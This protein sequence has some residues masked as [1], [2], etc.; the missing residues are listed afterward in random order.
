MTPTA[1]TVIVIAK[2]PAPG[3]VKTRLQPQFSAE[4]AADLAA[5]ALRDTLRAVRGCRVGQKIIYWAANDDDD[6]SWT[7]G[8]PVV[9]Q[10]DGPLERRLADAFASVWR[11][12]EH[13][14]L[15]VGM[16]TPQMAAADLDVDWKE[17]DAVLGLAPDGGFWAIGL[18]GGNPGAIFADIPM[19]TP[20]TGAAQLARLHDLGLNVRLLAPRRDVDTSADAAL[21]AAEF[22]QL[23]FSA[24]H[25]ELIR[26]RRRQSA[27]QFFDDAYS[28]GHVAVRTSDG[29][30]PVRLDLR[31]WSGEI[32]EV[33]AMVMARCS[34]PVLDLGCGP[35]RLLIALQAAGV[36]ALGVD[37]S[38]AAVDAGRCRGAQTLRRDLHDRLPSEGKWGTVVLLDSN[39]GIGGDIRAMLV[40]CGELT[41]RGGTILCEVDPDP[42]VAETRLVQLNS[43]SGRLV[44][45]WARVGSVRVSALAAEL[46]LVVG[47]EW[48]AGGRAFL[49]LIRM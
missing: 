33:D 8:F 39:L 29:I 1:Q 9:R 47:E 13:P 31:R 4:E 24:R 48:S 37:V 44:L 10:C 45:P 2:Q 32:D 28:G 22:P 38:A 34:P 35:G 27:A 20:R 21:I 17:A 19:S 11:R 5:A 25:R 41:A 6:A 42:D 14:A 36:A 49:R 40:R 26:R 12:G 43:G 7:G 30:D 23:E 16:D 15:L 18:R 46:D 3:R